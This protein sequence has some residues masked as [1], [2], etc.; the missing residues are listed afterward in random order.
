MCLADLCP[1]SLNSEVSLPIAG[2]DLHLEKARRRGPLAGSPETL[3]DSGEGDL[4][5]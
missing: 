5:N 1:P 4:G 2:P 3:D